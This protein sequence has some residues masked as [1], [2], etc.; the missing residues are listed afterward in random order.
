MELHFN[1]TIHLNNLLLS[2]ESSNEENISYD[3]I[4]NARKHLPVYRIVEKSF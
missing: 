4:L 2:C 3:N 1:S